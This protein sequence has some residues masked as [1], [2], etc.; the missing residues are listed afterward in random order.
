MNKYR[1]LFEDGSRVCIFA[2]DYKIESEYG[3][4]FL[5]FYKTIGDVEKANVVEKTVA[6]F[7]MRL[8]IGIVEV[9]PDEPSL[10]M[11]PCD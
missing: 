8:V 10:V 1:V 4:S 2:D 6:V 11:M 7:R 3:Y 5:K 9:D